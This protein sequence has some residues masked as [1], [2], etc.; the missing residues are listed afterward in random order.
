MSYYGAQVIHPKTIKPLQN[1]NIPLYVKCF[2]D[3]KIEGTVITNDVVINNYPPLLVL[4]KNQ[5]LLEVYS[6]DFSFITDDKLS[7]IY[8]TFHK[9]NIKINVMQTAAV[10]FLACVDDDA[11]KLS[12]LAAQLTEDYR[13]DRTDSIELLTIRHHIPE[14][15]EHITAGKKIILQ[16]KGEHTLRMLLRV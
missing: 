8:E 13:I 4:K 6:R 9:L 15:I 12:A 10:M 1:K 11:E 16:Q 5:V 7:D 14:I 2:L 3:P